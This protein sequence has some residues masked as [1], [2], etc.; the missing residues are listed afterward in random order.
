MLGFTTSKYFSAICEWYDIKQISIN[1]EYS[2]NGVKI[3]LT[4]DCTINFG[5]IISFDIYQS[6]TSLLSIYIY[7]IIDESNNNK[8]NLNK[9]L[10]VIAPINCI[11]YFIFFLFFIFDSLFCC[12]QLKLWIWYVCVVKGV[13]V[14]I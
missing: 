6:D 14:C 10:F 12:R 13:D 3:H 8:N 4:K 1:N 9:I 2:V 7:D 11:F 5:D